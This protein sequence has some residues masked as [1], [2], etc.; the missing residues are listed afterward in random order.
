MMKPYV[1]FDI[2]GLQ[3][4]LV[5]VVSMSI[6]GGKSSFDTVHLVAAAI[7]RPGLIVVAA[8]ASL[9]VLGAACSILRR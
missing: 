4:G 2:V 7:D 8:D 6:K 5:K 9:Q 1:S 3:L